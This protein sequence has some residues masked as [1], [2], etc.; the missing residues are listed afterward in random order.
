LHNFSLRLYIKNINLKFIYKDV[1]NYNQF[2]FEIKKLDNHSSG[3]DI[4]R[5][6]D[7]LGLL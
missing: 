2:I 7:N 1:K 6:I 5:D 4:Y 3:G